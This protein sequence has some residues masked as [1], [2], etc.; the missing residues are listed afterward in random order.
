[1]RI[2]HMLYNKKNKGVSTI[3]G[4]LIFI[5][6]IFTSVVPMMLVMKQADT[7]Y[8]KK[9]HE[10]DVIDDESVREELTV[11]TFD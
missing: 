5:G 3:L 6:I 1:M 9:K 7:I 11:Y 10:M 4:T 2:T 8:E